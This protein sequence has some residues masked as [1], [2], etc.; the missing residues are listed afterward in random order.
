M[1][2]HW[3]KI[4]FLGL[5]S[6]LLFTSLAKAQTSPG[7]AKPVS[8]EV[9]KSGGIEVT[10][11]DG[12]KEMVTKDK[13][14]ARPRVSSKGDVGWT[15]WNDTDHSPMNHSSETLHVRLPDG[16][17]KDFKPNSRFVMD[18]TFVD[19]DADLVIVSMGYHGPNYYIK[20]EVRTGKLIAKVDGDDA[21]D[22]LPKWA[23]PF[24][25]D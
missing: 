18:W 16:T 22:V 24:S 7:K 20:Y 1:N 3:S 14:S 21:P 25:E 8:A 23:Q 6:G 12:H 5:L 4:A 19:K 11:S 17:T 13:N 2:L 9:A 15:T 10:F